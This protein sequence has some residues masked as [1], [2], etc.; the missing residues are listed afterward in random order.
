MSTVFEKLGAGQT[1]FTDESQEGAYIIEQALGA[2]EPSALKIRATIVQYRANYAR[3]AANTTLTY[4][5][6]AGSDVTAYFV[7]DVDFQDRGGGLQ[8]W[9]R[10]WATIPATWEEPGGTFAYTFP[11]YIVGVA[12]GNI[13][14][15]TGIVAN[16]NFFT[17]NTN[18]TGISA[19][20][21]VLFDVNYIRASQNYHVTFV[22]PAAYVSSGVHV[23]VGKVFPGQNV[24]SDVT[25]VVT[26]WSTGR[27]NPET[28]EVDSVLLHEYA[29]ASETT[30]DT[31]LPQVD[32]W[33]PVNSSGYEVDRLSSG[34]ATFPN[35][36]LYASMVAAGTRIPARR[37][38][39]AIYM[40]NI[41]ERTTLLV[42]AR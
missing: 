6:G 21:G 25:G 24:F 30:A 7:D 38:D 28:I 33:S 8:S 17:V 19:G 40:G 2:L 41:Y 12:F 39:R 13:Y 31:V 34:S 36:T 11:S 20:D 4:D 1:A 26:K 32:K 22:Q 18:A 37:S 42:T 35:S 15:P 16:G 5:N 23:G 14:I 27:T 10:I 3:P 29:L 9:T